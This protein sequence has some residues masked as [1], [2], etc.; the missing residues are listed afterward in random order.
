VTDSDEPR[1]VLG[2]L[3]RYV[4]STTATVWVEAD[5]PAVVEVLGHQAS[6]FHVLGHHYALVLIEDLE[7][8]SIN[9]YEV[10]LRGQVVWPPADGRP[11]PEI[12]TRE[13]ERQARLVFGSC[14]VGAPERPPYT[15]PPGEHPQGLGVDALWAYSLKLQDDS[16]EWPDGL[17]LL[18][19]QVYADE[20]PPDTAAF[21]KSRRGVDQPPGE[22]VANFE[23]YTELY[24]ESWSDP[25]I[26]WLLSTVPSTMIFDDH[27]VCDDWN[28]SQAWVEEARS[29]PWWDERITGAF[30]AYWLYQHLGNL[31]PPELAEET[32]F[33]LVQHEEDAGARL[34]DFARRCD[35]ESAASRWAYYRDFGRS[36]L[37]VIDSR[38]A[39]VLAD[40]RRDMVDSEEWDWIAEHSHGSFDHL[41]IATTLPAFAPPGIHHLEAWN[42]AVCDGRWG[43]TTARAGERLRRA[44]DLEHWAAFQRSF[45]QL[46]HLLR[47]VSRGLG[48]ESPATISILSGDVHTTYVAE[49]DLGAGAGSS[50]VFQVV[51][52]PFRNPLTPLR[53]RVVKAAGSRRAAA[54][55]S[56][57]A[58]ACGVPRPSAAWRYVAE[59]TFDNS[60]GELLLD[61]ER[62]TVSIYKATTP[63]GSGSRPSLERLY[64][65]GL[66][67]PFPHAGEAKRRHG[68]H[69]DRRDHAP[70]ER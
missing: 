18:G 1:L 12:R 64:A 32:M 61:E 68:D 17:L 66:S 60:I 38:A 54:V 46:V 48:G 47:E 14:R 5:A 57:L 49:V 11:A 8:G 44:A 28:I 3:L 39:R 35:R 13:G 9:A 55:F 62:A 70:E 26:R 40:G 51:C 24:R 45:E 22:S 37:L 30:M 2:P 52:S 63:G 16:G 36:R 33:E 42:E 4:G 56:L 69:D 19:D 21:I 58:R 7:P 23:E 67:D 31:S 43:S 34:R 27:E 20:V 53:R 15:L 65:H 41:I 50:R 59:R 10:R 6:T 29:L 25:D